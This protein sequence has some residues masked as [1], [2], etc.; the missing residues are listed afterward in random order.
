MSKFFKRDSI[1]F[2]VILGL[3]AP[4]IIFGL[5]KLI[6]LLTKTFNQFSLQMIQDSTVQL[7]AI[8]SNMF[9]LRYYLV[10][11]KADKTGR[12]ILLITFVLAFVFIYINF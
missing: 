9:A 3:I 8:F 10:K 1:V 7:V 4:I 2:G 5:F 6:A 12:G 11:L